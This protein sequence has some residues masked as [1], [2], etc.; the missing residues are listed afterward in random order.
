MAI[1]SQGIYCITE[2][3]ILRTTDLD[4]DETFKGELLSAGESSGT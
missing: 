4:H 2:N 3:G 1:I